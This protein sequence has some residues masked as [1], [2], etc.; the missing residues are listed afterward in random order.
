MFGTHLLIIDKN[1][2]FSSKFG[3]ILDTEPKFNLGKN[4]FSLFPFFWLFCLLSLG[5]IL[6][7]CNAKPHNDPSNLGCTIL[8]EILYLYMHNMKSS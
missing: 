1:L 6:L 8:L 7:A 5:C 2:V 4:P 3:E